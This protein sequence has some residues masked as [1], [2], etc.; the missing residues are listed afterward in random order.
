MNSATSPSCPANAPDEISI[1]GAGRN[2]RCQRSTLLDAQLHEH[3]EIGEGGVVRDVLLRLRRVGQREV[4]RVGHGFFP[5]GRRAAAFAETP[6]S[7]FVDLKNQNT[8]MF[9]ASGKPRPTTA[10]I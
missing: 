8:G 1:A 9:A 3:V 5:C 7:S 2:R 4:G 10:L 6:G